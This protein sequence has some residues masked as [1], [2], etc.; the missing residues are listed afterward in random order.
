MCVFVVFT[1]LALLLYGFQ[2]RAITAMPLV[3]LVLFVFLNLAHKKI[4]LSW[5]KNVL[6]FA[7][8][9]L[10]VLFEMHLLGFHNLKLGTTLFSINGLPETSYFNFDKTLSGL[11]LLYFY[12]NKMVFSQTLFLKTFLITLMAIF[13]TIGLAAYPLHLVAFDFK[14]HQTIFTWSLR[15]FFAVALCEE[16]LFRG[17]L[18]ESLVPIFSVRFNTKLAKILGLILTSVLF[19]LFYYR[20]GS[21]MILLASIAGFFYGWVYLKTN[22]VFYSAL[23]HFTLNLVHFVF[24]TYP[25]LAL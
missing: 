6:T 3:W 12:E 17:F 13:V 19:G 16:L 2:T 8:F 5:I 22:H 24:F 11:I 1:F 15:N 14:I 4:D 7:V 20:S 10:G 25:C 23:A 18:L 9:G 21:T